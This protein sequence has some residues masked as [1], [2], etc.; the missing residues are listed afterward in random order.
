MIKATVYKNPF[1]PE[2]RD[3]ITIDL[4]PGET[5]DSFVAK[6][7]LPEDQEFVVSRNGEIVPAS[8]LSLTLIKSGDYLAVC[9]AI[10]GGDFF[11]GVLGLVLTVVAI[12]VVGPAVAGLMGVAKGTTAFALWS[13]FGAAVFM[14]VGGA[15][16]NSMFPPASPDF[17]PR[18]LSTTQTYSWSNMQ[19]ISSQGS[20]VPILF[21][22]VRTAGQILAEHV[23][24]IDDKQYYNVLLCGCEGPIDSISG[25]RINDNPVG[26][27]DGVSYEVR[28]G[29]NS[30][31]IISNF[32]DTFADKSLA[33]VVDFYNGGVGNWATDV[34]DGSAVQGIEVLIELPN[35]LY[36]MGDD[37]NLQATSVSFEIQYRI[38]GGSWTAFASPTLSAAS[39]SAIRRTYRIDNLTSGQ[40]EVRVRGLSK[41]GMTGEATSTRYGNTV[42]WSML[43]GILYDDFQRPGK[44]LLGVKALATDQL[45]GGRP[46]VSWLQT[47]STVWVWNPNASAYEQRSATNPAWAC[48]DLIHYARRL[49]NINAG[50]YQFVVRGDAA[51]R[52][53][54][55]DFVT[56]AAYCDARGLTVNL[57]IEKA[58]DLWGALAQIEGIG[59]GKCLKFGTRWGAICD[60]PSDPVQLFSVGNIIKDSFTEEYV[61]LQDR[62]NAV[63]VTYCN[64]AKNYEKDTLTVYDEDYDTST[65]IKNPTQITLYGITNATQ[66]YREAAYRLRL[67]KYLTRTCKWESDIDAIGCRVGDVVMVQHDV[68]IYG[69]GGRVVSAT[70]TTITIDKP[71]GLY[72]GKT[73][74]ILVRAQNDTIAMRTVVTPAVD[75]VTATLTVTTAFSD[76]PKQ[77]D[78][79]AF[80]E[81]GKATMPVR[82]VSINR[83]REMTREI[84]GLEYNAAVYNEATT[85]PEIEYIGGGPWNVI[86]L[87]AEPVS[88]RNG[89]LSLRVSWAPPRARYMGAI[90]LLDGVQANKVGPASTGCDLPIKS[91]KTYAVTVLSIDSF[92]NRI[93]SAAI[94]VDSERF[95]PP[96]V[97]TL[98]IEQLASGRKRFSWAYNYPV[99]N[100]VAGFR[101]KI[102]PLSRSSWDSSQNL[103]DGLV[104]ASPYETDAA[105]PGQY[106]VQVKAVDT[107][108]NESANAATVQIGLGDEL[109]QNVIV[110]HDLAAAGFVGTKTNCSVSGGDLVADDSGG[111]FWPPDN[112]P[113]WPDD[114]EP[115]WD[116]QFEAMTYEEFVTIE[117]GQFLLQQTTQGVTRISYAQSPSFW[118]ADGEPFWPADDEPFWPEPTAADYQPYQSKIVTAKTGYHIK[119][120][121]DGGPVQ[122]KISRLVAIIDVPDESET[123]NDLAISA[124]GTRLP[125]TKSYLSILNV[126]VSIQDDGG[127]ALYCRILD[128]DA[129]LGPLIKLFNSSNVATTG[130]IDATPQGIKKM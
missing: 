45:S 104:A 88:D 105:L 48:Y 109:V 108:G 102:K 80:G 111:A 13:G 126:N 25:I 119:V 17:S 87:A 33:Y 53:I 6:L 41:S 20:P 59:R 97:S 78:V 118:P 43:S 2:D 5:L 63:E 68:P 27:F 89:N 28:L 106:V 55:N 31:S 22:T 35:G 98:F 36:Y 75:T 120:E 1:R 84:I 38:A 62:A 37:G 23:S 58:D 121:I 30:Q 114:D 8:S 110:S 72:V 93:G 127:D 39:S 12:A 82:V 125:L 50:V 51:S 99:P 83:S 96:D 34:T 29:E 76:V 122:G 100:D 123:I 71:V 16:L 112:Y 79:Y 113:F 81:T 56:W 69:E 7:D 70:S 107:S 14:A 130:V 103:F 90:V 117:P 66:A 11:K 116:S 85:I 49:Y 64:A 24:A 67:N 3:I 115:F 61:S 91:Y 54:Y 124:G 46:N 26:N 65:L 4:V 74:Q 42:V 15:L 10:H 40:Y 18:D 128:K 32:G 73:Y 52:M 129:V 21:G 19:S 94:T 86:G 57:L 101:V 60:A 77:F 9:P 44:S 95:L 92:G 47:R